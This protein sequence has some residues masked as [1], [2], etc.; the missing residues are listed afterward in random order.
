M[1]W[2]VALGGAIGAALRYLAGRL[3]IRVGLSD[4]ATVTLGV[5]VLG[6]FLMGVAAIWLVRR[7]VGNAQVSLFLTTGLL[8]GF[9]TFSTFSLD[10]MRLIEEGRFGLAGGYAMASVLLGV[11]AIFAGAAVARTIF[12]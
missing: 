2:V 3:A 10:L 12:T 1:I 8:G 11:G 5:N 6:S 9:T 4:F 7:G